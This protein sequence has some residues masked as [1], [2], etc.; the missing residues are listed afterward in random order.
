MAKKKLE[1]YFKNDEGV[2]Q[3][4]SIYQLLVRAFGKAGFEMDNGSFSHRD[5]SWLGVVQSRESEKPAKI[6][7]NIMFAEDLNTI[8]GLNVY[9]VPLKLIEDHDES[10]QII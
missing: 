4:T 7:T 3:E 10:E 9:S 5:G 1:L 6:T 2:L 8:T